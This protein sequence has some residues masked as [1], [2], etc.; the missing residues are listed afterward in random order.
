MKTLWAILVDTSGSMNEGF[1]G[2]VSNAKGLVE[3]GNWSIKLEAAKDILYQ[4]V[5]SLYETD[6]AII[7]FS[8]NANIIFKG[9]T[10]NIEYLENKIHSLEAGGGTDIA[11]ALILALN[12]LNFEIYN[13]ISILIITDGLSTQGNP[14]EAATNIIKKFPSIRISTILIDVTPDGEATARQISINGEV[15]YA[16]SYQQL[17]DNTKNE[18]MNVLKLYIN[19]AEEE[20]GSLETETFSLLNQKTLYQYN[21]EH[22]NQHDDFFIP[23]SQIIPRKFQFEDT[24]P[25]NFDID[26]LDNKVIPYLKSVEN[27][28]TVIN[29]IGQQPNRIRLHS[30]TKYSPIAA[31]ISGV[32]QAL[33][34]VERIVNPWKREHAKRIAKLEEQEKLLQIKKVEAEIIQNKANFQNDSQFRKDN[35]IEDWRIKKAEADKIELENERM[36]LDLMKEKV[37]FIK[38]ILQ[39]YGSNL[40]DEERTIYMM[41]LLK[42][43]EELI[44]NPLAI[45][46]IDKPN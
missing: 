21:L 40:S 33:E 6:I 41:K 10:N 5:K 24:N 2:N 13:S 9:N 19:E 42:P 28:Q 26:Y 20:M 15:K 17:K 12:S 22:L 29:Q 37:K 31:S 46:L 14:I 35:L 32:A 25:V 44:S 38:E 18:G 4:Q 43:L 34:I 11:S 27:L 3:R 16:H 1:S 30:I 39:E 7:E 36:R 8:D 45:K 23:K